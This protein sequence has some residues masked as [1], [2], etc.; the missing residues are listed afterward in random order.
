MRC[1]AAALFLWQEYDQAPVRV[2]A[3]GL[4][5]IDPRR[6]VERTRRSNFPFTSRWRRSSALGFHPAHEILIVPDVAHDDRMELH[7]SKKLGLQAVLGLPLWGADRPLGFLFIIDRASTRAWRQDEI[8]L[9]ESFGNLA[10]I[11]LEKAWLH[12]QAERAAALEERQRL[13]ADMHDG[14]AQTLSYLGHQVDGLTE[15]AASERVRSGATPESPGAP[16]CEYADTIVAASSRM[17][18]IID[19]ATAEV[20]RFIAGLHVQPRAPRA[21]QAVLEDALATTESDGPVSARFETDLD[22]PSTSPR[23]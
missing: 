11:I 20:R 16:A 17:R 15:V 21:L 13:A 23:P 9:A 10:S 4:P 7:W 19:D 8:D 18:G 1:H 3:R 5:E 12:S 14:L 2:L 6:Q 22:P